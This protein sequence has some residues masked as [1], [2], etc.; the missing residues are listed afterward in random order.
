MYRNK[1]KNDGIIF[2]EKPAI[3]SSERGNPEQ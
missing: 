1:I 3:L 2:F